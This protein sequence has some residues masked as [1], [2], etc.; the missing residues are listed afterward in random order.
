VTGP[1]HF[2]NAESDL[3]HAAHASDR[4]RLEDMAY[5]VGCAQV[6]AALAVAAAVIAGARL[7]PAD[8]H[9]WLKATDPQYAAECAAEVTR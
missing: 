1:E 6:H 3:E 4:D 2:A 8:R 5:W 9:E 7:Q